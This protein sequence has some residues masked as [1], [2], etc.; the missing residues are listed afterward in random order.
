MVRLTKADRA[1][2]RIITVA[3]QLFAANGI[4]AVSMRQIASASGLANTSGVQYHFGNRKNLLD[5]IVAN[6]MEQMEPVRE[7][8]LVNLAKQGRAADLREILDAL[9]SP[10]LTLAGDQGR[11]TYPKYLCEYLLKYSRPS[12]IWQL[13]G[14]GPPPPPHLARIQAMIRD[15]LSEI[16]AE[17]LGF[18]LVSAT[19]VILTMLIGYDRHPRVARESIAFD[20][21][22]KDTLIQATAVLSAEVS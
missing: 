20:G 15:C 6:R 11:H 22:W 4:E 1:K 16:P 5:A 14:A 8:L 19:F 10:Y 13:D 3:E 2:A 21:L 9:Y 7:K 18:R 17:L 12:I